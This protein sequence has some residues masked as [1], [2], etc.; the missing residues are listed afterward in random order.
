[1]DIAIKRIA[2]SSDLGISPTWA[3]S[4]VK[5]K[6]INEVVYLIIII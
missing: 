5:V 3:A 2:S 4:N 6:F 1:M